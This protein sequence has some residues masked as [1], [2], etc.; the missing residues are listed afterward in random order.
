MARWHSIGR[1]LSSGS[2]KARLVPLR[3]VDQVE[4]NLSR[5]ELKVV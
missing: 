3:L 4:T 1:D 5:S 2:N